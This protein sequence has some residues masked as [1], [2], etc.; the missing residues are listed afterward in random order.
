M[1]KKRTNKELDSIF[2]SQ[3]VKEIE[4]IVVKQR[5]FLRHLGHA[6][7]DG[8][9]QAPKPDRSP[10]RRDR[11]V[12]QEVVDQPLQD[13]HIKLA[14][15]DVLVHGREHPGGD[16]HERLGQDEGHGLGHVE[17]VLAVIVAGGAQV[18]SGRGQAGLLVVARE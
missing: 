6:Q 2:D 5:Q 8:L 13:L 10:R 15:T 12:V 1:F 14:P 3:N 16:L 7:R 17:R 11:D 9:A 18:Q 4:E